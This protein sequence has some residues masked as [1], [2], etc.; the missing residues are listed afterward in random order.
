LFVVSVWTNACRAIR[1]LT[2]SL[3]SKR[4]GQQAGGAPVI[5]KRREELPSI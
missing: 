3:Y 4:F 5:V 2:T 1:K